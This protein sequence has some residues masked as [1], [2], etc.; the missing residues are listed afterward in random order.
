M[1]GSTHSYMTVSQNLLS[2]Y[3][4]SLSLQQRFGQVLY[5]YST[6][7]L[8]QGLLQKFI[9]TFDLAL[10][11]LELYAMLFPKSFR[12]GSTEMQLFLDQRRNHEFVI[13]EIIS[14]V[15]SRCNYQHG[16]CLL[17]KSVCTWWISTVQ[18]M[19]VGTEDI[20]MQH[21]CNFFRSAGSSLNGNLVSLYFLSNFSKV[22]FIC[23]INKN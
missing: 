15:A 21:I 20:V 17:S 10:N 7:D 8:M 14:K 16:Q 3:L 2:I 22:L 18:P 11:R 1:I 12:L 23:Q 9:K 6:K 19:K 5:Y 13:R 4:L